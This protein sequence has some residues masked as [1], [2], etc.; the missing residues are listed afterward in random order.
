M[1]PDLS[2][3][4]VHRTVS[5]IAVRLLMRMGLGGNPEELIKAL[6]RVYK[7]LKKGL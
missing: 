7:G 2:V 6:R 1:G 5:S 3:S 4:V